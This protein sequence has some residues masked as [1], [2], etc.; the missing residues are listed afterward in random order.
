MPI[1][2]IC[3]SKSPL[4]AAATFWIDFKIRNAARELNGTKLLAKLAGGDMIAI[5]AKY[6]SACLAKFYK[7][8]G[9][10]KSD[11]DQDEDKPL[12]GIAFADLVAYQILSRIEQCFT[13]QNCAKMYSSRLCELG[14]DAG[15]T[16]G[17]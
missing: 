7:R 13:Y 2:R 15:R 12:R 10:M 9:Q 5:E 4:H 3:D 1:G 8:A 17:T 11:T 14:V 16:H 6:H